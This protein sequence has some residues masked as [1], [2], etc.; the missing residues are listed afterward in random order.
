MGER[1][2]FMS[3]EWQV[4]FHENRLY[5]SKLLGEKASNSEPNLAIYVSRKFSTR[6]IPNEKQIEE[7]LKEKGFIV[8]Y[9]EELS[10][11]E[12]RDFFS[13]ASIV[14]GAHG[15]GLANIIWCEPGTRI[16]E[17]VYPGFQNRAFEELSTMMGLSHISISGYNLDSISRKI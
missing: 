15:A 9:L 2:H 16:F 4:S 7:M 3:K 5:L 12:Q 8:L 10:F 14:I 6:S 1:H 13:K 11:A 17:L